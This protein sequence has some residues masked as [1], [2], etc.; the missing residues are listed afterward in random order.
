MSPR[1]KEPDPWPWPADTPVER[2]RRVAWSY[3]EQLNALAPE[4]CRQLDERT[5]QLGQKWI[6]PRLTLYSDDDQ[7]TIDEVADF[8]DVKLGTVD[9]WIARGLRSIDTPDGRRFV[10]SDVLDYHA[11][12]RQRR[13]GLGKLG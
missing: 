10:L 2:A 4:A 13:A 12:N 5:L 6:V 7:L 1:R 3:R 11:R 9:R 8:C